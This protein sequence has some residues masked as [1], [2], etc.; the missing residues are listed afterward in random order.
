MM[1]TRER[2][3]ASRKGEDVS[4]MSNRELRKKREN[5]RAGR[6]AGILSGAGL[7]GAAL[8]GGRNVKK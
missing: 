6:A 1:A 8:A 5:R 2:G 4:G 3:R 7:I